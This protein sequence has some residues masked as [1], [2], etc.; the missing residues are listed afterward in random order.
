MLPEISSKY[1]KGGSIAEAEADNVCPHQ[2]A[3]HHH[4]GTDLGQSHGLDPGFIEDRKAW[5]NP[6]GIENKIL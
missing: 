4:D 1:P 5:G 3:E 2:A 6:Q